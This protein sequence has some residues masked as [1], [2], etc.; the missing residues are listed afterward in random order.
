MAV[1][2]VC[3]S[4]SNARGHVLCVFHRKR[5]AQFVMKPFFPVLYVQ[6]M[7]IG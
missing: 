3:V 5:S 2:S 1:L 4:A 6:E 7:V